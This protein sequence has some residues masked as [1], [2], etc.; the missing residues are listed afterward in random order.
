MSG[1]SFA[2]SAFGDEID[3]DLETQLRVMRDLRIGRLDLR[4]AWGVNVLD[5]SDEQTSAVHHLCT[6]Y[7]IEVCCL[8]S[9]VG[10]SPILE[11][12]GKEAANL[13][14]LFEIGRALGARRIRVFSFYPP[15]ISVNTGYDAFV[16][17]SADRLAHLTRL[18]AAEGFLLLLENEK[19]IVTDT[20]ERCHA[21]LQIA[22]SANLRFT[23][24][25]A[26]FVQ[27]G[28]A[29]PMARGWQMLKSHVS[30]VHIKDALL[31]DGSVR[32]AG[33]GD[34]EVR[35]LL[36]GLRVMGYQG[37]LC[38]EP[39]LTFAGA[40][41]GSSG[42]EG[43]AIAAAALRKLMEDTGCEERVSV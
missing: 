35:E 6:E 12:I 8:G 26:N 16:Q 42:P 7:G 19:D 28:V 3:P 21:V 2:L 31:A 37:D 24:D 4:G 15:D 5:L 29:R 1:A 32:P 20:P 23:W 17:L 38:L 39:H 18:A 10:K 40:S 13:A 14:R 30:H 27:V 36:S 34:G 22:G 41:G 43:M 9:P 25:P 11:P 33:L